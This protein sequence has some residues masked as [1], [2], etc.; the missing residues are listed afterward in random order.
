MNAQSFAKLQK[1]QSQSG[2]SIS[3]FCRRRRI[4]LSSYHYWRRRHGKNPTPEGFVE[5]HLTEPK[6][7]FPPTPPAIKEVEAPI[8]LNYRGASLTLPAGF[9][10]SALSR[11]LE[12]L[13]ET[14]PC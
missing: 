8:H 3:A 13:A 9:S 14:L 2:L 4:A 12:V 6:A 11:C 10:S 1:A 7:F 5:L